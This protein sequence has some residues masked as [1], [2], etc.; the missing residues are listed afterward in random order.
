MVHLL[1]CPN[2]LD[3]GL[4]ENEMLAEF[5][6][7]HYGIYVHR[8]LS[9]SLSYVPQTH[10]VQHSDVY[11]SNS[12]PLSQHLALAALDSAAAVTVLR[13]VAVAVVETEVVVE[14]V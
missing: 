12:I 9:V 1:M 8:A 10:H 11:D 14:C 3:D 4:A 7:C 6:Y 13:I 2:Q 5:V